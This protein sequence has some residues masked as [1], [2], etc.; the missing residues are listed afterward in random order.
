V[1]GPVYC[2]GYNWKESEMVDWFL[3]TIGFTYPESKGSFYPAGL[4][5]VQSLNFYSKI[6]NA[7]EIDASF[8]GGPSPAQVARWAA[9]TPEHFRFCL[10]V[11]R[12]ITHE[13]RLQNAE[14]KMREFLGS[15]SWL[16]EKF[17][18]ALVQPPPRFQV[19]ER[20][21]LE[22]FLA[23]LPAGPRYAVEFRH[24]SWHTPATVELLHRYGAC[25]VAADY[26]DL[27]AAIYPTADYLYL[28]W[29]G[30]H[31]V[32]P[33]PG[34]EVIDRLPRLQ[35]WL[36]RIQAIQSG[37]QSIFGFFDNDYAGHSPLTCARFKALAGLNFPPSTLTEQGRLFA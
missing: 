8:Y 12:S 11:P 37:I 24:A 33:H 29:I 26:E 14:G 21:V 32:I 2:D 5:A 34:Y 19:I 31:N 3:G 1:L 20:P 23:A 35:G 17:G 18:A 15:L 27:P 28:R 30:R 36:E 16:G 9:A 10:K 7:V 13:L 6:F 4:P 25:F 22:T